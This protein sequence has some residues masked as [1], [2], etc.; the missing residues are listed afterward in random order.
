LIL[1]L[2]SILP[3]FV[4]KNNLA[5]Q[6]VYELFANLRERYLQ[7]MPETIPFLAELFE[8]SETDVEKTTHLL[9]RLLE[10]ISGEDI[11]SNFK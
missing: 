3:V 1:K 10:E 9:I 6:V 8:D 5:P 11:M 4:L 7:L 2:I